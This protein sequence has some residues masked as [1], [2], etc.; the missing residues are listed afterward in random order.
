MNDMWMQ[1][2]K[3]LEINLSDVRKY[4]LIFHFHELRPTQKTAG[5]GKAAK[6]YSFIYLF[7]LLNTYS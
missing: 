6:A 3:P 7:N 2:F 5:Q 1:I 4:I